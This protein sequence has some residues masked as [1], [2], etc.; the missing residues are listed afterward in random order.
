MDMLAFLG[1][2]LETEGKV[3]IEYITS[4]DVNNK[5]KENLGIKIEDARTDAHMIISTTNNIC[6]TRDWQN[7]IFL[8]TGDL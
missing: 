2:L 1:N 5:C 6:S 7:A 4:C 8:K 3:I